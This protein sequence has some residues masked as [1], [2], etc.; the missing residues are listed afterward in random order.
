VLE[1]PSI[2]IPTT[3]P[4]IV[5]VNSDENI[6]IPTKSDSESIGFAV[7]ILSENMLLYC[8]DIATKNNIA[9]MNLSKKIL[10]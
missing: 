4:V 3:S 7:S 5:A 9:L 8:K 1:T 2:K 6:A 10:F